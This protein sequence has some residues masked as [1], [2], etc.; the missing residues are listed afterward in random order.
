MRTP[1]LLMLAIAVAIPGSV[2]AQ[3]KKPLNHDAYNIWRTIDDEALSPDG[4][5][6]DYVLAHRVGDGELHVR[7]TKTA[8]DHIVPRGTGAAFTA[9]GGFVV[10]RILPAHDSMRAAKLAKEKPA[11]Q[12]HDS[13]GI[14]DLS[15]GALVKIPDVK[16]FTVP[17]TG[18]SLVAYLKAAAPRDSEAEEKS[19]TGRDRNGNGGSTLVVRDL[20]TGAEHAYDDVDSYEFSR[21]GGRL[22]Y[23]AV[24][25]DSAARGVYVVETSSG[26]A[27]PVLQGPGAYRRLAWNRAGDRLAFL[28]DRHDRAADT[29]AYSLYLWRAGGDQ[30]AVMARAGMDG[31][32]DGWV[33]SQFATPEFSRNGDRLFFETRPR[34][35]PEPEDTLLPDEEVKVDVWNWKDPLIQPMQLIQADRE[36][37]RG[38]RAVVLLNR[39]DRIVQLATL[40][41]PRVEVGM[42]GDA[43][44]ALGESDLP[45]RHLVGIDA[46]GW[47][48][49]YLV[50]VRTG[51]HDKVL[52][53][54]QAARAALSPGARYMAWYDYGKRDWL[55]MDVRQREPVNL[56]QSLPHAVW[57][58][59]DDH[60]M[61]PP[62]YGVAGWTKGDRR[63]LV[64]DRFD[65]W[66]LDPSGRA[67]PR[68]VTD[69][70]GRRD[71]LQ[72]RVVR[73]D[74]DAPA[75]DADSAMLLSAF[76]VH[77]K[78]AG[79]YN[80]RVSGDGAPVKLVLAEKRFSRPRKASHA[81]VLLW[82]REDVKEFPD[83]WV[84]GPAFGDAH[85][86]SNANP[87]QKNYNW[88]T[89]ELVSWISTDG[90]PLQGLLYKPE[91]FDPSKKYPMMV[92]FYERDSNN[93]YAHTPPLP[94]RSVIRPTF[95][96]SRGYIVFMPDIVYKEGYPG[97]SAVH[98]VVPGVLK[99]LAERPYIDRAHIG[100]QGHSWGGYQIAYMI[101]RTNLFAAAEAGAPVSDM[102]SAYGGLR[103]GTGM[104]RM[105][106]YE[107]TQSRIGA[108]LWAAP[109]R[110]LENSPVF[111]LDRVQTPVLIMQNDHDTAVPFTQGIEM[112]VGLRRLGK[113]V[114]LINY[115]DMPHWPTTPATIRD[116]N[117]RMQQFFDHY[118][119]GAPA[120]VWLQEGVPAVDKGRTLGLDLEPAA[121]GDGG[122]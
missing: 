7:S 98:A 95:Y 104:S 117:I 59:L 105:F 24:P 43:D 108:S 97:E 73:L 11:E 87:Q 64:Y 88:A 3:A 38:Y 85:K 20:A 106:Q 35:E 52:E 25:A 18:A 5:W 115:N 78:V 58:E 13:L 75:I 41:V 1:G 92:N 84:S 114:W 57:N 63:L 70:A 40:D 119:K 48:D 96:A 28:T 68:D 112:F 2:A 118:L 66:A 19:G 90:I 34:P 44:V 22:A 69:G 100:V 113:P 76:N 74:R 99:L 51:R 60:P 27:T 55:A 81:N 61:P 54:V 122:R 82:T 91:N 71:S 39:H 47:S 9:D 56:T 16:S 80:D 67:A 77:T 8:T 103:Y 12:P 116:W 120:P 102:V 83:L 65:I 26:A 6:A 29:P 110:Y 93:L 10:F 15:T 53:R 79:F 23:A 32:P 33:V 89:V 50:D 107:H 109:M 86:I 4:A 45:Y 30:P 42:D 121:P 31:V 111:A 14:L 49:Y 101:T 72:F 62:P 37:R 94:H 21:D 17:G 36:R 46:P